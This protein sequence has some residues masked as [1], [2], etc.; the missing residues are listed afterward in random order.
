[1]DL[2]SL[3]EICGRSE[4]FVGASKDLWA[5]SRICG[6]SGTS[7]HHSTQNAQT[8]TAENI[9]ARKTAAEPICSG[10]L[11]DPFIA[12]APYRLKMFIDGKASLTDFFTNVA[13]MR[14]DG[15][16]LCF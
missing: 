1:M 11:I 5:F 13:D 2:Q 4:K 14:I 15:A 12:D 7:R 16:A 9:A 10:F 3:G 8:S 6:R